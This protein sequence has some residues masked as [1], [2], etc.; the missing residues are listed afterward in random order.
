VTV[1]SCAP[2]SYGDDR[3]LAWQLFDL[4]IIVHLACMLGAEHLLSV[5]IIADL[6]FHLCSHL[7]MNICFGF[8]ADLRLLVDH[9]FLELSL[10]M[11]INIYAYFLCLLDLG[12]SVFLTVFALKCISLIAQ[13]W[14]DSAIEMCLMFVQVSDCR[15]LILLLICVYN[16]IYSLNKLS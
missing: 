12:V 3:L 1:N 16:Y 7:K 14:C 13:L 15:R 4:W 10:C 2:C 8:I 9:F 11:Y 6:L 5:F